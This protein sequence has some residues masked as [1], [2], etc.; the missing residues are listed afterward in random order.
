VRRDLSLFH[1]ATTIRLASRLLLIF[2][3]VA[4]GV[5]TA[6]GV[7]RVVD[8]FSDG[9]D[10][11]DSL[12]LIPQSDPT[13]TSLL[14]MGESSAGGGL[15]HPKASPGALAVAYLREALPQF[16]FEQN[17][18]YWGGA[19]LDGV[20]QNLKKRGAI[21]RP[22]VISVIVGHNNFLASFGSLSGCENAYN[23]LFDHLIS[24]SRLAGFLSKRFDLRRIGERPDGFQRAFFDV[25]IACPMR[26]QK[27]LTDF[28]SSV[29]TIQRFA[30]R[31]E[32]PLIFFLAAGNEADAPPNRSVYTGST[33]LKT[34]FESLYRWG[35]HLFEHDEL[36]AAVR[37]FEEAAAIDGHYAANRFWLGRA[38]LL[39]GNLS[40]AREDLLVAKDR[41]G[42]PWRSL[43]VQQQMIEELAKDRSFTFI[44]VRDDLTAH[45]P[46]SPLGY[47]MFYDTH[48]GTI[49]VY[50]LIGFRIAAQVLEVSTPNRVAELKLWS[51]K[52]AAQKV[53]FDKAD[54]VNLLFHTTKWF[55]GVSHVSFE[56]GP[57]LRTMIDYM[58]THSLLSGI[59]TTNS[60]GPLY[61][62]TCRRCKDAVA[63]YPPPLNGWLESASCPGLSSQ[64]I[65][66]LLSTKVID[67][68]TG[69]A[70]T[71]SLDSLI[72]S[73]PWINLVSD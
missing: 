14:V 51:S 1:P 69:A 62:E 32:I 71:R 45:Y 55:E 64:Q 70:A 16:T 72:A 49:T 58:R 35:R 4:L 50:N 17:L 60:F 2:L 7:V 38:R 33:S 5:L 30:R 42:F 65:D 73:Y 20:I 67:C 68:C 36:V 13:K 41:D 22:A 11:L 28:R 10:S 19:T 21:T 37:C 56:R 48:H 26:W 9:D 53:G 63:T 47:D 23:S 54:L 43:T 34:R 3:G 12:Q 24:R 15:Y 66:A 59:P 57:A 31:N 29:R 25:P 40:R 46:E 6:E 44:S 52:E 27:T 8:S 39:L 61:P 18:I